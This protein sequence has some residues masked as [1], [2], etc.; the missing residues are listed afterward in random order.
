MSFVVFALF[1][2]MILRID[3]FQKLA[4]LLVGLSLSGLLWDT[5]DEAGLC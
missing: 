2:A 5:G 1:S 4:E 3:A